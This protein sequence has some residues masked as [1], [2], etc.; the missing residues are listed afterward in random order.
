MI[1]NYLLFIFTFL[2]F[3]INSI[4]RRNALFDTLYLQCSRICVI[5]NITKWLRFSPPSCAEINLPLCICPVTQSSIR[6]TNQLTKTIWVR[7]PLESLNLSKLIKPKIG[8]RLRYLVVQSVDQNQTC[9]YSIIAVDMFVN[10]AGNSW[11]IKEVTKSN[12]LLITSVVLFALVSKMI[13]MTPN[14]MSR[15]KSIT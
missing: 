4:N 12:Y 1:K 14:Q 9:K 2:I 13:V 3:S 15:K 7:L 5:A 6:P 11:E 10:N 8:I